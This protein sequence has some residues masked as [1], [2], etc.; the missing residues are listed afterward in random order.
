[1]NLPR[2]LKERRKAQVSRDNQAVRPFV[3]YFRRNQ[4]FDNRFEIDETTIL[5]I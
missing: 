4:S 5:E 2:T 3:G 1:M